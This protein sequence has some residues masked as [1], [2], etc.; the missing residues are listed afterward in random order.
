MIRIRRAYDPPAADGFRVLIDRLWPRG[1]RKDHAAID[2][3][4]RDIAPSAVGSA[5]T[6]RNG[7]RSAAATPAN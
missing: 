2:L 4:L 5:T 3:W 6:R 7:A 1:L